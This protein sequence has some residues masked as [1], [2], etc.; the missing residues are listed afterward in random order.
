LLAVFH[1]P[2]QYTLAIQSTLRRG[3]KGEEKREEG[4]KPPGHRGS[5]RSST[6]RTVCL[7]RWPTGKE[8][9]KKV[10]NVNRAVRWPARVSSPHAHSIL[11]QAW[12]KKGKKKGGEEGKEAR[13]QCAVTA[14]VRQ[15]LRK[16]RTRKK[17]ERKKGRKKVKDGR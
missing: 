4:R 1:P 15:F 9:R 2:L 11:K 5:C 3:E 14:R 6:L 7:H 16:V 13:E 17:K 10:K 12:K 8:E